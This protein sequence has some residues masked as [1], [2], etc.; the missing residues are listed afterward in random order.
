MYNKL[1]VM[2]NL[3]RTPEVKEIGNDN[4]VCNFTIAANRKRGENEEVAYIDCALA[5]CARFGKSL[6]AH[7]WNVLTCWS[8]VTGMLK[9]P[10]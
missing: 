4:T 9:L 5:L 2:G 10:L 1:I 6:P 7:G 8:G 3:V